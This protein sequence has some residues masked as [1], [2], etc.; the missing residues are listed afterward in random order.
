MIERYVIKGIALA[1]DR[2]N[3]TVDARI[4]YE[5]YDGLHIMIENFTKREYVRIRGKKVYLSEE[6]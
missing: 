1:V 5:E 4:L 6:G 2:S 3:N